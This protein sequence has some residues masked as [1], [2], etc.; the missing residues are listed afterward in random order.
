MEEYNDEF[1][2]EEDFRPDKSD[3][4][5]KELE[6]KIRNNINFDDALNPTWEM[7]RIFFLAQ[8][9][10]WGN[11]EHRCTKFM[12]LQQIWNRMKGKTEIALYFRRLFPA[13]I[14]AGMED[15]NLIAE[16]KLTDAI[17]NR[18]VKKANSYG[19]AVTKYDLETCVKREARTGPEWQLFGIG[20]P[21]P[22]M[23][24]SWTEPAK[25]EDRPVMPAGAQKPQAKPR[26]SNNPKAKGAGTKGRI[27]ADLIANGG[28]PRTRNIPKNL[29]DGVRSRVKGPGGRELEDLRIRVVI[30]ELRVELEAEERQARQTATRQHNEN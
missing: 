17:L 12:V 13:M 5:L 1:N 29:I 22:E 20:G 2:D 14:I 16:A 4:V 28:I 18:I 23:I 27:K 8:A 3:P 26:P 21:T 7:N 19:L 24:N 11:K 9:K 30:R 25:K 15:Q 6:K 10:K